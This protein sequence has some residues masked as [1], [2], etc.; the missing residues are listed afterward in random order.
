MKGLFAAGIA[1]LLAAPAH[2][3]SVRNAQSAIEIAMAA[4]I[5]VYGKAHIEGGKPYHAF[6]KDGIWHVNGTLPKNTLGGVPVA[7]IRAADGKVLRVG[8]GK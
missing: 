4:W 7:E 8:H 5:P 6:L 3:E 2:A 1:L